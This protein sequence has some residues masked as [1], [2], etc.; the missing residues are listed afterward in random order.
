[1]VA[2]FINYYHNALSSEVAK[3]ALIEGDVP[4]VELPQCRLRAKAPPAECG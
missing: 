3:A 1:M 2:D 4:Q